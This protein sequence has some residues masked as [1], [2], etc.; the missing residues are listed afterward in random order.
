MS[1]IEFDIVAD[2][3]PN[4]LPSAE[5][6]IQQCRTRALA[7][8]DAAN[9]T[10][11]IRGLSLVD[12]YKDGTPCAWVKFGP[13][14][15][16]AKARTQNYVAQVVNG[17]AAA[18]AAA[19]VVRVPYVYLSFESHGWGYIV[20]E[21]IDGVICSKAD[22]RLVAAAVQFLVTIRGPTSQPDPIGGGP[23]CHDFFIERGSSVTY[24]SVGLLKKHINGVSVP[25]LPL[26]HRG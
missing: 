21:F 4:S 20:M 1:K 14:V 19:A 22:A 11:D 15:T 12:E 24:S 9:S 8:R 16:M 13:S 23:I 3:K 17:D 18:A 10:S 2:K 25:A 5:E 26:L 7:N 6:I